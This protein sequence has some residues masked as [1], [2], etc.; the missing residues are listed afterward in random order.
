MKRLIAALALL[1]AVLV[2]CVGN[3]WKLSRLSEQLCAQVEGFSAL[4]WQGDQQA[5]QETLRNARSAW[6]SNRTF[7]G[8]VLPHTELD[9][10]ERLFATSLQASENGDPS[11]CRIYAAELTERL[12]N[13]PEREKPSWANIF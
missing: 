3:W 11:E 9:E 2:V 6:Q 4:A 12:R 5:A 1:A 8:A 7:L 10:V 13:L